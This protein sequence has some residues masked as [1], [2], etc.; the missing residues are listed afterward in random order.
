[1]FCAVERPMPKMYVSPISSRFWFG[2][3][4]P[5]M[6][7]KCLTLPLL[8]PRI[9]ADDHGRTVPLDHAAALAHG[10]D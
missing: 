7:A 9:G 2:R 6:R 4:T 1:M 8:V 5:A 3:L 10:L